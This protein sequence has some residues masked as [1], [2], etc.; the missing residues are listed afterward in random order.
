V[1]FSVLNPA[2]KTPERYEYL[3]SKTLEAIYGNAELYGHY[4]DAA[5][6]RAD[7][8]IRYIQQTIFPIQ[9][10]KGYRIGSITRDVTERQKA[11]EQ[12]SLANEALER[13]VTE[14]T[15]ELEVSNREL[16]SFSYTISHDLRAPLRAVDG[17]SYILLEDYAA[18]LPAEVQR[19]LA[20]IRKNSQEMGKLIDG[21]LT[22]SRLGRQ[23]P[24]HQAMDTANLVHII[25]ESLKEANPGRQIEVEVGA[26]PVC[27]GDP[28]M[29]GK[30]WFSLLENAIKFTLQRPVAHIEVG[31]LVQAGQQVYYVKDNGAGFDM[32]YAHKL[33]GVFQRLHQPEEFEGAGIGLAIAQRIIRR[34]N[35]RM[36]AE[37]Q[38][39][40][41]AT[42][43]FTL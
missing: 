17:Y 42:F 32:Q 30:V 20:L 10:E 16:E 14:R 34:H 31:A 39:D 11:Q 5:I 23:R 3:R 4:L 8:T 29:L 28:V 36:W 15:A 22:F 9:T 41:G 37:G 18:I 13:K 2:H 21:L 35:G 1:Q 24:A 25:V 19:Y 27:T 40:Q 12:V 7:G 33:F 6:Y 43:Y 38:P 26:L